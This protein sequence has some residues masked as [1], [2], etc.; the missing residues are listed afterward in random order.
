MNS[1]MISLR[2]GLVS[3]VLA[4]TQANSDA[5]D[6]MEHILIN[7]SL[8]KMSS[9]LLCQDKLPCLLDQAHPLALKLSISSHLVDSC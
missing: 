1:D 2:Q 9:R 8:E 4:G 7:P 5:G 3:A 6:P